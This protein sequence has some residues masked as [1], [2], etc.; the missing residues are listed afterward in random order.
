MLLRAPGKTWQ[1]RVHYLVLWL[2]LALQ[3][4]RAMTRFLTIVALG[5]AA[6]GCNGGASTCDDS[7][8][9]QVLDDPANSGR[10]DEVVGVTLD[11]GRC[12]TA[13]IQTWSAGAAKGCSRDECLDLDA[14]SASLVC[15][16]PSVACFRSLTSGGCQWGSTCRA[17]LAVQ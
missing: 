5:V 7:G 1:I 13:L 14:P 2:A 6:I 16:E 15:D 4:R 8:R 3:L 17:G 9:Q 10:L 12:V 11:D